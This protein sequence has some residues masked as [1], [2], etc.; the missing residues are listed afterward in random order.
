MERLD[1]LIG[2]QIRKPSGLA[3]RVL[4]HLMAREHRPLVEWMLADLSI[5]PADHVLDVGCGGGMT[6]K[7]LSLL[8]PR[9]HVTGIDYSRDMVGQ[10]RQRNAAGIRTGRIDVLLGDVASLPF[11]D[12]SFDM[13]CG[14]ET[15]YFWPDPQ[16]GMRE[17]WR[18]LKPGCRVAMVMD[19]SRPAPDAPVPENVGERMGFR[20]WSGAE[21]ADLLA[22]AGLAEVSVKAIPDRGKGW[23]CGYGTKPTGAG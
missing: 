9:G 8:V 4:G 19:I 7:D 12:A 3:G 17:I 1:H 2:R 20:V 10:A 14:V 13:V 11:A 5:G 22:G 6:L 15:L 16:R 23:L 21:L 18:V